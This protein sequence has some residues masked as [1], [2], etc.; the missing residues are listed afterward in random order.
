MHKRHSIKRCYLN[1]KKGSKKDQKLLLIHFKILYL[2]VC[3]YTTILYTLGT[4]IGDT[5]DAI[6]YAYILLSEG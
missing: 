3:T 4:K 5:E 2:K 6:I 1:S